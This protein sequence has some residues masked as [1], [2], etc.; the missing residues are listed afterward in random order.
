MQQSIDQELEAIIDRLPPHI[1]EPLAQREDKTELL[2][3][4]VL[5]LGRQPEARFLNETYILNSKEV[6]DEDIEYVTQRIGPFGGDNRAGL[7]RTLHRISAIRNRS[8][9]IVGLTLRV[10]R[11][12]YGTIQVIEDLI[13]TGKSVLLLGKPGVGKTTMLREVARVLADDA[14]KRVVVVDTSNEI[15]GDGDIPHPGIGRARRMQVDSPERQHAVMI[16]GVENH[17]PEVIIIDEIGTELEANAARTI[18]ERGVQLVATAHGNTLENLIL[19]PTLSDL[20]GGVQ[21]VTLGDIEARRRRTQKTV[22]ERRAPPTFD[23]LVEIQGWSQVAIHSDV[24]EVVDRKLRGLPIMPE[25]RTI[26]KQGEVHRSQTE[27]HAALVFQNGGGGRRFESQPAFEVRRAPDT[28]APERP[29]LQ[30]PARVTHILPYGVNKGKLQQAVRGSRAPVELVANIGDA[31]L[32]LTTKNFYRRRT[33]ALREAEEKGKPVYVL[34]K[35]TTPQIHQFFRAISHSQAK[36][37]SQ[38]NAARAMEEAEEAAVQI[39]QGDH[40]AELSPQGAYIRRL[41]HQ[42]AEQHGLSSSSTGREPSR[43]V[44]IYRR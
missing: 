19:N 22:L 18:A 13:M 7:E 41:Q 34:R 30:A 20:V 5:D 27:Q 36:E 26:D 10:G 40:R 25:G 8:G 15:A 38:E 43:H 44:V 29:A 9:K 12:V 3:E 31:D 39:D 4:V 32:L 23:I 33:Q 42:I 11:A 35:N 6:S 14:H 24:A 2:L 37:E 1:A 28:P 21:A 17:M 16:E